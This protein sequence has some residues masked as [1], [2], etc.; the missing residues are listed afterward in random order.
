MTDREYQAHTRHVGPVAG[1]RYCR[2][3]FNDPPA[4]SLF[5][6]VTGETCRCTVCDAEVANS[7]EARDAHLS[8]AGCHA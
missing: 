8:E 6:K 5:V 3:P 2:S 7:S 1:C 4:D